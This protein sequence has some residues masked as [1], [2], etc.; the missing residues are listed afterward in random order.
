[1]SEREEAIQG[2]GKGAVWVEST[3]LLQVR[4]CRC[5]H[6]DFADEGNEKEVR[7][8]RRTYLDEGSIENKRKPPSTVSSSISPR[9]VRC[10]A[11]YHVN[12]DDPVHRPFQ[13]LR[14]PFISITHM[15]FFLSARSGRGLR[16][17]CSSIEQVIQQKHII[18]PIPIRQ[19]WLL[20]LAIGILAVALDHWRCLARFPRQGDID[21]S[22]RS[23]RFAGDEQDLQCG[24]P[25]DIGNDR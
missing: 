6:I 1:M 22:E 14:Y 12:P 15:T 10:S 18:V 7:Q 8:G 20:S 17:E 5:K 25:G 11:P 9:Q 21:R 23:G 13:L 16:F 24:R 2:L 4:S 19:H 3:G